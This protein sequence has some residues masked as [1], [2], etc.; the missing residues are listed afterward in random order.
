MDFNGTDLVATVWIIEVKLI[1]IRFGGIK[2]GNN[3]E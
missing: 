3:H 1:N 2:N